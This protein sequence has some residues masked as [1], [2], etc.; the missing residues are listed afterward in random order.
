MTELGILLGIVGAILLIILL[1]AVSMYNK[2]VSRKNRAQRAWADV[3][4]WERRKNN[5]LPAL[6]ELLESFKGFESE[7]LEKITRLRSAITTLD[8]QVL[9]NSALASVRTLSQAV[10]PMIS[11]TAEHYPDLKTSDQYLGYMKEISESE[12]NV[13]AALQIF[14]GAVMKFNNSIELFP[15]SW[16]NN[17]FN[18]ET[19]LNQFSSELAKSAFDFQPNF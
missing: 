17:N 8:D 12:D 14:N 11:A 19:T 3:L 13:A 9:D 5:V 1:T 16:I 2:I 18:K 15:N 7:I 6:S 10:M 4:V